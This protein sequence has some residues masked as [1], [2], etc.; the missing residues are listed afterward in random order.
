VLWSGV[1]LVVLAG[2]VG[3]AVWR[4]LT[5]DLPTVTELLDYRPPTATRVYAADGTPVGEFYIE[6]RYLMPIAQVPAHVRRAFLAAEDADFYQHPGIDR[7]ASRA[8]LAN[9]RRRE[10]VQGASTITQQVVKHLLLSPERTF[11]RKAKEMLLAL[12]L[13]SKLSKD[14]SS[15][16]T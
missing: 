6:R 8:L 10:I 3:I 5:Q 4:E 13:E 1:A 15:T 14:E 9:L 12:E 2:L 7:R 11:E 16:C